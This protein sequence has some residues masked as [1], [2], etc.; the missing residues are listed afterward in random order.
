[1]GKIAL[2][3]SGQGAQRPGMG[4]A[5]YETSKAAYKVFDA[6][7]A[8][9]PGTIRQCFEGDAL[10]LT[11]TVNAQPCL[12]A[13]DL[14]CA[15]AVVEGGIAPDCAAG[16]SLG[17]VAGV[18]FA[19]ML[20]FDRAFAFVIRRGQLMQQCG[21]RNPGGMMAALRMT[22]E[23]A[24][25]ACMQVGDAWPVNY[26]CPGQTVLS[27]ALDKMDALEEAV[28]Q[29]GGRAMRLNVSGAFHSPFMLEAADA[30]LDILRAERIN[31]PA[32]P[33][34]ANQSAMLYAGDYPK[35]LAGQVAAPV[36]WQES[37]ERM[38]QD[39]V[40]T[41]IEIGAGATLAGLIRKIDGEVRAFS[42]EDDE[43]LNAC[44]EAMRGNH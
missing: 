41:F 3:F 14:A 20:P 12:F 23:Q 42:V 7:E 18:A 8:L 39:G 9:R 38:I 25:A 33:L 10:E 40:D 13:V 6:A 22:A 24:E 2:V 28:K 19:G 34:Y 32:I 31:D 4:R 36:R 5:L 30:L 44:L 29:A 26:N 1:M 11:E 43:S 17:E 21:E 15:A 35:L 27:C 37:V 16:F